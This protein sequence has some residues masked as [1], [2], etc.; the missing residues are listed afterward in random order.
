M[1]PSVSSVVQLPNQVHPADTQQAKTLN[2]WIFSAERGLIEKVARWED[3][4][5]NLTDQGLGVS[6]G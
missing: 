2:P 4:R 3:K 1:V 5:T 6:M